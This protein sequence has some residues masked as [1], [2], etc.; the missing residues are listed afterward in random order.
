MVGPRIVNP[1]GT[2][3]RGAR[4]DIPNPWRIF[5]ASLYLYRLMPEHPRFRNYNRNDEP[6]PEKPTP[7]QAISG[8]CM[9]VRRQAVASVGTLDGDYFLHFEDLDWCL[10]FTAADWRI[11]FVPAAV[12]EHTQGI[13]SRRT[14]IRVAYAKHRSLVRFLRKHFTRYYPSSFMA[15]VATIVMVRFGLIATRLAWQRARRGLGIAD[16]SA[17]AAWPQ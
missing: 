15:L 10:R 1:D 3:Q 5:C 12:V 2:E 7:M 4:R 8:A 6:L 13:C 9:L 14:P 16:R 11:V 17:Q